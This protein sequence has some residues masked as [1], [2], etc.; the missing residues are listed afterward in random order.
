M[1]LDYQLVVASQDEAL[2]RDEF[3]ALLA[4]HR[5]LDWHHHRKFKLTL[6]VRLAK[7]RNKGR[8]SRAMKRLVQLGYLEVGPTVEGAATYRLVVPTHEVAPGVTSHAA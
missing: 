1:S 3:R 2:R 6:L 4:C 5:E 8:A 7:L